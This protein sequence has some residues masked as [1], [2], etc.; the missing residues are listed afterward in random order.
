MGEAAGRFSSATALP[1]PR[2]VGRRMVLKLAARGGMGDVYLGATTGLE[3][4]ER[5][6]IVKTVRR[7]HVHDGSFLA[8]FL[9]EARVQAQLQHPGIAQVLE[10]A[11]DESGEPYTVVEY[12]EGRALS[13]VRQR[14]LQTGIRIA[15]ADAVAIAVEIAQ[16]L[17]HVHE[18]AGADGAPLGI[19]HRDLSPQ[20]VMVGYAGEIK[21][22]DFGTARGHNRR[23]HTVAGVVF[24]KPG[25]VAP[26]VARQQVGDGRIDVYALGVMIW[27]LCKGVRFLT[28]DPQRHLDD[29]AAGKVHV[30]RVAETCG[31]PKELDEVIARLTN[32]EPDERF[33]RAS[34]AV[35]DLAKL[36]AAAPTIEGGERGV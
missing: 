16:A 3:G 11:S 24:A 36:L 2:M 14:A 20:N 21:L 13:D 6:C 27:E 19:V 33:E 10:A 28:T 15:W 4:T 32:N 5:P 12:V 22:I 23:C 18:R 35:P 29:A 17:A 25:Y 26:E 7:D 34:L 1:L 31:A 8:R 9:D 30:A